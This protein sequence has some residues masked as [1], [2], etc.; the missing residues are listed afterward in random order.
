M[1]AFA[2]K[3]SEPMATALTS[4]R[5]DAGVGYDEIVRRAAAGE[6]QA[7]MAGF[8]IGRRYLEEL[9][10]EERRRRRQH[11]IAAAGVEGALGDAATRV[12]ALLNARISSAEAARRARKL[13][14]ARPGQLADSVRK[15][16]AMLRELERPA[17]R[18]TPAKVDGTDSTAGGDSD[19]LATLAQRQTD[20]AA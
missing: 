7:G 5:L 1:G 19:Y 4:A 18:T 8:T 11:E 3:Y 20:G 12:V 13:D 14:D 15:V 9:C 6:L 2:R 10:S 17:K 16:A